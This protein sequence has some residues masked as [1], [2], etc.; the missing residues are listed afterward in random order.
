[1]VRRATASAEKAD[2]SAPLLAIVAAE[3]LE[4]VKCR[5]QDWP[6]VRHQ[7]LVFADNMVNL[8]RGEPAEHAIAEVKRLDARHGVPGQTLSKRR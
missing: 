5:A 4:L 8:G 7:L 6:A 1:M 2:P 3:R